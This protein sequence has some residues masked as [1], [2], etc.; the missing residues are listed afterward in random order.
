MGWGVNSFYSEKIAKMDAVN[1]KYR[2]LHPRQQMRRKAIAGGKF[3]FVM[4]CQHCGA[5]IGGP[6]SQSGWLS[7]HGKPPPDL[8]AELNKQFEA[9]RR[10]ELDAIDQQ[11]SEQ[12]W[13]WYPEYLKSPEWASRRRK[14]LARC[15]G[16]CEGCGEST[17]VHVH[18]KTYDHVGR[19]LLFELVGLCIPCHETC[20]DDKELGRS[21]G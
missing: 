4:Q 9:S 19:E 17:A 10:K 20:H 6:H 15:N 14:V 18:H 21:D 12:F 7:T 8:D 16:I 1:E 11:E 3:Q 2:C 5:T 13:T